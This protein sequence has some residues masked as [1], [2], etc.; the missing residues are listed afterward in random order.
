MLPSIEDQELCLIEWKENPKSF[1]DSLFD[2]VL[3]TKQIEVINAVRDYKRVAVKSGNTVGKSFISA[4]TAL[5]FLVT[6]R[7]SKVIT[8]APTWTQVQDIFW[9]EIAT[10]YN[11]SKIPIGGE[12]LKTELRFNEEH[13]AMGI[14]TDQ[15]NR[16]QGFHSP[17]LLI[18][19]DEALGV[20]PEIWEAIEGLHPYRILAIGNPLAP[21][22]E[23]F[24]AFNS[25]LW[26][27]ITISCFD[28][29]RWQLDNNINI[30]GLVTLDW[31]EERKSEWGERNPLYLGRVLGEFPQEGSD[32]LIHLN[33]VDRARTIEIEG[34]LEES[35]DNIKIVSADIARYGD[36]KTVIFDRVGHT[37]KGIEV[38]SKIPI[39]MTSG[40]VKRHYEREKADTLVVDDDGVG[41]GVTDILS[42]YKIGVLAFKGGAKQKA[43]DKEKFVNLRSQFYWYV[44]RKFEKGLYSLKQLPQQHFEILKNQLCSIKYAIDQHGRIKIESKDDML[45]RQLV[46]PDYADSY[47]MSEYGFYMGKYGEIHPIMYKPYRYQ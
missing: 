47:I 15:A 39:T 31:I 42:S 16:F 34:D 40:I 24:K 9:K 30:P 33:W 6:H 12:L 45:A 5:W 35:E 41:G 20:A 28:A 29:V 10:S 44:A 18:V 11:K 14:S 19:I 25:H 26:H 23:F 7:P 36:A 32:T 8:T 2:N 38:K 43:I 4:L 37:I 21:E 17:Y 22:G 46:S 1:H 27:K 13:F 3:W